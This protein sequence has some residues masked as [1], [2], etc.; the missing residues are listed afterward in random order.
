MG[1]RDPLQHKVHFGPKVRLKRRLFE[2]I[3]KATS[4]RA[5]L[6]ADSPARTERSTDRS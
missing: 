1:Y 5:S 4:A 3:P 2:M 6:L